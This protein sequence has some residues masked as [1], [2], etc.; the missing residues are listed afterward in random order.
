MNSKLFYIFSTMLSIVNANHI[1]LY[2]IELF[3]IDVSHC[4]YFVQDIK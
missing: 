1:R 3:K 2:N 4:K